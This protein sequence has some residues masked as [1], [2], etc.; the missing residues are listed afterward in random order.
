[1]TEAMKAFGGILGVADVVTT[2]DGQPLYW[3]TIDDTANVG[4][5]LAE[6]VQ[7]T[8]LDFTFGQMNLG[9]YTYTSKITRISEQLLRTRR[10]TSTPGCPASRV[11]ASAAPSPPTS[12][13]APARAAPGPA[14]GLV[15]AARRSPPPPARRSR[16][17]T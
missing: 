1:M 17:T 8:E 4:A 7:A 14:H 6:N 2:A 13:P 9:A 12:S 5:I 11:S 16:S 15:A 3:P 10:S